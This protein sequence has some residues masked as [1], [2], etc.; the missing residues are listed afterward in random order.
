MLLLV[1]IA[2]VF[3]MSLWFS[4]TAAAPSIAAEFHL[5][6]GTMAWLTMAVQGGFVVGTL[7]MSLFVLGG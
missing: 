6:P 1:A 4:A 5:Q 2:E 3:G 7:V